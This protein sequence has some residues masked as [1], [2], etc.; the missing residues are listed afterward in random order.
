MK[1]V[2]GYVRVS[3]NKQGDGVSLI[4]QKSVI[5]AFTKKNDLVIIR[6]FE[7]KVTA[8]KEGRPAFNEMM[9]LLSLKKADGTCFHKIDRSSRNYG[10]W[11]R[12]NLLADTGTDF[13]SVSD[14][15]N[16]S[17]E[18][19]RLPADIMAAMS[20]H[21]IR[22]L[23]QE[24]LKGFYGRLKQGLYP[25][26][27]PVGY[28]DMGKGKNKVIHPVYGSLVREVFELY[29]TGK[30]GIISLAK[31][32]EKKGLRGK[33]GGNV[34][35]NG[36]A[37]ILK[38]PFYIGVIRIK[39]RNEVFVG[40]HEPLITKTLFNKAQDVL[41]GK[42]IK[43]VL[44]HDYPFRR[45]IRCKHCRYC[46]IAEK[47]KGHIYYRCHTK[48]CPTK[49]IRQE[50]LEN[51]LRQYCYDISL[52]ESALK[53]IEYGALKFSEERNGLTKKILKELNFKNVALD[54]RLDKLADAV[55]DGLIEKCVYN[56]KKVKIVEEQ[57]EIRTRIE[58]LSQGNTGKSKLIS[59]FLE[60]MKRLSTAEN[61]PK[62]AELAD[63]VNFTTSN[64]FL[65]GKSLE[66]KALSPFKQVI[67]SK[68]SVY[69][70]PSRANSRKM[71]VNCKSSLAPFNKNVENS[72]VLV[73]HLD[74]KLKKRISNKINS[75]KLIKSLIRTVS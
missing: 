1:K 3:T 53:E 56:R 7:E 5:E 19:S 54:E 63:M 62:T 29:S 12:I 44:K 38:N 50:Q 37:N 74:S 18:T 13:Y 68:K 39:A 73:Y 46:L 64:L 40:T 36:I 24:V 20:T 71:T 58:E 70:T 11:N 6:W 4:E 15:I 65:E 14:G 42:T 72:Q 9:K 25:L 8:A 47:Q 28:K 22:N 17:D 16:L 61:K 31:E 49:T 43:K 21:F 55:I 57:V 69:G 67:Q 23:R 51:A 35:Q 2:Y 60:P 48:G 45:I 66:I 41:T 30:Y 34:T 75:G 33:K 52:P 27:A 32:M 59:K 26:P 10:D